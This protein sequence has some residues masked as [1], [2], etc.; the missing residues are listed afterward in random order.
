MLSCRYCLLHLGW[1]PECT[2]F[3]AFEVAPRLP[4]VKSAG[5]SDRRLT[6]VPFA[7]AA[8]TWTF[9]SLCHK[10]GVLDSFRHVCYYR[11]FAYRTRSGCAYC[12][13]LRNDIDDL[14]ALQ[15]GHPFVCRCRMSMRLKT[16]RVDQ[17]LSVFSHDLR[18]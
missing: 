9:G 6:L 5:V 12:G 15:R 4:P 14:R 16:L 1:H 3:L 18:T 17:C 11:I 8:T 13:R 10:L 7:V 2:E